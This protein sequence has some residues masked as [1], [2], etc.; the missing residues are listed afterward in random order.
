MPNP[1]KI[2]Q[3]PEALLSELNQ[4]LVGSGFG[5]FVKLSDWLKE[6]G[7]E[8]SKSAVGRHSQQIKRRLDA[9]KSA[10]ES[11]KILAENVGDDEGVMNDAVLRMIQE[12]TFTVLVEMEDTGVESIGDLAKL[13]KVIAPLVNAS[14]KQ[15][16][17]AAEV[18]EK[19][20]L[21]A[22]SV[23]DTARSGG[24]SEETVRTIERQILG[25][26]R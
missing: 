19:A 22:K 25:I 3:L 23:A 17:Y 16:K 24:L 13:G 26:V 9:I 5:D 1:S 7:F 21:A 2:Q 4:R 8:I 11:A 15:K 10:T 14:I 6:Q 20:E 12:K 18:K